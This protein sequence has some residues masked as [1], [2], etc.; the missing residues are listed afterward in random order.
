MD[1]EVGIIKEEM[2]RLRGQPWLLKDELRGVFNSLEILVD[3]MLVLAR[4]G[5]EP[6]DG[7]SEGNRVAQAAIKRVATPEALC[8]PE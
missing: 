8:P 7:N 4:L 5:N 1:L 2:A 6:Y 3:A